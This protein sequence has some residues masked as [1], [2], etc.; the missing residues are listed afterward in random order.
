MASSIQYFPKP[1]GLTHKHLRP[2]CDSHTSAFSAKVTI[3]SVC[4][5][6][7]RAFFHVIVFSPSHERL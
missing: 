4:D 2:A 5:T 7:L 6:A 3:K 1:E